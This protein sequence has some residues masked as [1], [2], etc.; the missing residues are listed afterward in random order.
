MKLKYELSKLAIRD[1]T[2]IWNY[3]AKNWSP[4]QADKYFKQI[5]NE[6]EFICSN[7][8]IGKSIKD[9]KENH[10]I[11]AIKSHLII[12]KINSQKVFVDRILHQSMDIENR[13]N[14]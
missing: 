8:E 3:T 6:I 11:I 7:P 9:V 14:E 10:R 2:S 5:I 1:L 12:Y 13:L 4:N